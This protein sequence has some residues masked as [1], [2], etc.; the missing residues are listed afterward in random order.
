M[1]CI[2]E[3]MEM[4]LVSILAIWLGMFVFIKLSKKAEKKYVE[5]EELNQKRFGNSGAF[6][7]GGITYA[8]TMNYAYGWVGGYICN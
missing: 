3:G 8:V 5:Y 7:A 6:V 4:F 1:T 2:S